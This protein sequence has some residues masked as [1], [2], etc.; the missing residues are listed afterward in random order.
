MSC[1]CLSHPTKLLCLLC[2][3][4]S[5]KRKAE[6]ANLGADH[7]HDFDENCESEATEAGL[8]MGYSNPVRRLISQGF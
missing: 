5:V 4:G 8:Q 7:W 6:E 3:S 2:D 1:F